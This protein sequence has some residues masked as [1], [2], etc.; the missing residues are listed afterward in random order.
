VRGL[1]RWAALGVAAGALTAAADAHAHTSLNHVGEFSVPGNLRPGEPVDTVTAAE[2]TDATPDGRTLVYTDSPTGRLGFVDIRDPG[3][4]KAAGTLDMDGE[5][6]SVATLGDLALV[7]VNTSE[8]FTN[9]S[10]DLVVVDVPRRKVLR[11][12][13]LAGQPDSIAIS[14]DERWA[15]IV[16]ENER[17]EEVDDGLIPQAPPGALQVLDLTAWRLRTVALT[18][19]AD[20]APEDPEPEY[21]DINRRNQAV[22]S[23]QENN[24]LVIVD[25]KSAKVTRDF[26]AGSAALENVD[27]TEEELGPQGVGL[28]SLSESILRRREP[29]AVQWIDDDTFATANEGDYADADG[30][31]GGS[32]GFT[33]FRSDGV[34]EYESGSSF[35]QAVARIGHLPESRSANKGVEPEGLEVATLGGRRVLL[36]ASER[37]NVVGVYDVSRGAPRLLQLLPTGIGPEGLHVI[38]RRGLLAVASETDGKAEEFDV[39]SLITLYALGG[40]PQYPFVASVDET[41]GLPIPWGALSGLAADPRRADTLWSVSD[42]AYAQAYLYEIDTSGHPARIVRRIP[43]GGVGVADQLTGDLDLEGVFARP[44]GGFWLASEGRTND[45]SSR[46]NLI[47]R[48]AAS[49]A[50][51]Q[52]IPLP[53]ALTAGATSSGFEGVTATGSAGK[54]DEAVYAVLQREWGDDPA[55]TVKI[56]RYEVATGR[57]TF[58]RYELD[59]VESPSGGWV[60]LSEITLLPDGHSVAI[61]ER[62]DRIGLDARIKRVYGV[63]LADQGV[64]WRESGQPLDTVAK[65]PLR[66]VLGDLDDHSIS[67]PDKLEGLAVTKR[68]EVWL[69]T[70]NDAVDENYGETLLISLGTVARDW[71]R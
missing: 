47:V 10:G 20:H 16:I 6:T 57:W 24:H 61:V 44:E 59:A 23:L 8:S 66:D 51:L 48:T 37:A 31:E 14:P 13:E 71:L 26:S 58:A 50:V 22:V 69:A 15:A 2:I 19:L 4:P 34:V 29:D 60:G 5:P 11:R 54:G 33:L 62:D 9:P 43:V 52:S 21:V 67:V 70:D 36:V 3:A 42:S 1:R 65:S 12:I 63:D 68:G 53:A 32:R 27:A 39:R 38:E 7:A 64:T 40:R 55:G 45:G 46:P 17:D 49:G 25:L 35:E 56:A 41:P 28:I 30:V 18:G